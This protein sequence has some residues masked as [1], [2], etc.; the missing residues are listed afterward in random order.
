MLWDVDPPVGVGSGKGGVEAA[1]KGWSKERFKV[2]ESVMPRP[3]EW[4]GLE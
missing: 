2:F 1:W 3:G 4:A